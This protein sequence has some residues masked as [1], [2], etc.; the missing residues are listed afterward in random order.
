MTKP[1][2]ERKRAKGTEP[3]ASDFYSAAKEVQDR[4]GRSF[5]LNETEDH[6]FRNYF[7]VSA[8]IAL[9]AWN[10]MIARGHLPANRTILV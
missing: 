3:I 10:I 2:R 8:V 9:L 4:S 5:G 7:G 1:K 6:R